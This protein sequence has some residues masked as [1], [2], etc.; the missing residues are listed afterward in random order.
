MTNL[1]Q[2]ELLKSG[3]KEWNK[4][5]DN[6]LDIRADLAE[7]NLFGENL[8]GANLFR[9]IF[10]RANLIYANLR[11]SNL[12]GANLN[13]ANLVYANLRESNLS[14]A[15]LFRANF[16]GANLEG[17]N[18]EGAYL[19]TA[20]LY[21]ATLYEANLEGVDLT[22]ADIERANLE[23]AN[24]EGA[25]LQITRLSATNFSN[26]ILTGVCIQDW[27][28]NDKTNFEG[29]ICDYF[30]KKYDFEKDE[31]IDRCPSD[32]DKF[33]QQG[34]FFKLIQSSLETLDLIFSNG[35]DWNA[36]LS[37]FQGVQ[38]ES[39]QGEI[40][41][42]AIEKKQDGSFVVRATNSSC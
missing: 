10:F 36:F 20:T 25:N 34:D 15:N 26:A 17:A 3:V 19:V 18:L 39:E 13:Q 5:R 35:I 28:I 1:K 14:R 16:E 40:T 12:F 30:Y 4:W 27:H 32:P 23:G 37:S 7:A 9:T 31:F 11:E 24:L 42:Q 33:L 38:V 8:E 29:V 22:E 6:N 21:E 41:V 2:V